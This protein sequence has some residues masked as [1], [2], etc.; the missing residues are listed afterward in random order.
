MTSSVPRNHTPALLWKNYLLKKKHPIKWAFEV[1]LP[2]A[3]IVLLAGLKTLTDN[4]PIPAGWSEAPSTSFFSTGPTEG[5]AYNLFAKP[6]PSL[7]DF[8]MSSTSTFRTPK[9]YLTETTLSGILANLAASSFADGIRI[10]ELSVADRRACEVKVV[11]QG[12]VNIDPA[13]PNAIPQECR[14]KVVPYKLAI[15]PDNEFT[16]SYFAATLSTWYPRIDIGRAGQLNV[17]LP[18]FNDSVVFFNSPEDLEAYVTGKPGIVYVERRSALCA[19]RSYGQDL[20][21]PKI[22]AGLVFNKFPSELGVEGSIDYTLRFNSTNGRRGGI[23]D[24]P[25]TSRILY[26]PYQR[27]TQRGFLTLQT[28][29][30]RFA[31]CVPVW[32]GT[33]TTGECTRRNSRVPDGSL[34]ARF[35]VQVQND[36]YL[37]KLVD[38][39]NAFAKSTPR[40]G[41][42]SSALSLA[43]VSQATQTMLAMPLRQ[44]PQPYFGSAVF[45]F[46]IQAYTSSP[47][48]TLVDRYFA[49]VFVISYLYAI[50]SVLVALIHEKEAKSRELLKIMGVSEHAIVLSW[51]ITYGGVFVVAAILQAVAGSITLFPNTNVFLSFVFFLLFGLSVL[52]YGFLVSAIFSKARTG[53]YV[54]II[55]FFAMYLVS[56][57]FTPD[58]DESVKTLSCVLAPV[59]LSFGTSAL[60]SAETNSLGLSFAN[61]SDPYNNFRFATA[62]WMLALDSVLYTLLGMY[63]ELVVPNDYGVPLPWHFPLTFWIKPRTAGNQGLCVDAVTDS[64]VP[65]ED[66][67]MD[68]QQQEQ[69]GDALQIQNLRKVFP[70]SGGEKVAVKGMNLT[71]YKNQITCLLGHNGA[72]KTT[73]I[74][75]LTGM[76]PASSGDASVHGLSLRRD[77]PAIRQS[78]GMC[79]QHDVLYAELTV[80]E[81]LIFYGRIKGYRGKALED[82]VENKINEVGLTEK[83]HVRSTELSGGMK[84]KLSLAIALLGDSKIVFL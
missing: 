36:L 11:F 24:V 40:G 66:V 61:A 13:S 27:Y 80:Y 53:A 1:L 76:L 34:D 32:N 63:L 77:L 17:S 44:A 57:A 69:S 64:H 73:L 21:N 62:L 65:I 35:M 60:A 58:T 26:D 2:V 22:F 7:T 5:I 37:N 20:A 50:S 75:M 12:A 29:V 33:T 55:G 3:F 16:R 25:K 48:Y 46:P 59:A 39:A 8:L 19:G 47:F 18:G 43:A 78:L 54:G 38:D 6:T 52:S 49:L 41:N 70:V 4:V 79:P 71:M 15:V 81:H 23:G 68:L 82:E 74:S 45:P 56:A 28:A 42:A 31:T 83:R 51:Y 72:G 14:G 10:K 30:A 67:G 9:Y 84:R